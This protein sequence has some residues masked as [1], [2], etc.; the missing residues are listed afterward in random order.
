MNISDV[1]FQ[2]SSTVVRLECQDVNGQTSIGTGYFFQFCSKDGVSAPCI[3]TNKHV[4]KNAVKGSFTMTIQKADGS[5]DIG[6]HEVLEV[7]KLYSWVIN[8][9]VDSVD[10]VA[11]PIAPLLQKAH[12]A[13]KKHFYTM[14]RPEDVVTDDLLD[15]L[16][17][18]EEIV[19]IGYPNGLWDSAHNMPIIRRGITATHARLPWNGKPEFLIDAACFPGSSGSPVF[20][21]NL[22]SFSTENGGISLG[23]RVKLLGTLWGGPELL[24]TGEIVTVEV[25]TDTKSLSVGSIPMNL[26]FVIQASQLKLLEEAVKTV[27]D[28]R[29][30]GSWKPVLRN[31]ACPCLSGRRYKDCCGKVS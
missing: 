13:N 2:L 7:S 31:S 29:A 3:V 12:D 17:P 21:A 30:L 18:M 20:L 8:H 28:R 27:A 5:P 25:P 10:L 23:T 6:N 11:I 26:G 22:G 14:L 24:R 4:V 15:S 16:S 9:P 1:I 19:M